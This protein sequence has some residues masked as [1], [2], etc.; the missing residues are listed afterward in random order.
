M[1]KKHIV[2]LG[3]GYAG[4]HAAKNL[5]KAFKK[6]QDKVEITLIDKNRHHILMTELHEVAGNRVGEES[7]KIS[8]DRIFSGKMVNVVQDT[9][10]DIDFKGQILKGERSSY[11]YDQLIIGTGAQTADFNIPGVK[12]HAFYLWSLDDA[13]RIRCH[14]E[15][16]V[17]DASREADQ[18]K[19]EQMLTFVI[20]GGGFTGVELVGEL[21][22][23]LPTLCKD[24]GIDF[25]KEVRLINCEALGNILNMLPEKPRAKAVKYMEKKGV[26]IM[27]NS[28]ITHVDAEGFTTRH[29]DVIKTKTLIWTCGV[30]GTE[31]CER[32]P[33]TDGKIGRKAVNEYMQSPDYQNV[34]L[35]G[36]GMWFLENDRA[37]PQIVEAAE[38][39]AKTAA[40]GVTY[41]IKSEMGIKAEH[42]K[43]FKS[44][45]HGFMVSIG[46]RYAVSHTAGM[47]LSGFFA[48]ALKHMVNMYYQAGVCGINGAWSYF[49]HE[50]LEIKQKRS[51]I[52]G[53]ASYKVPSYWTTFLR[54][55]LGVMW[56]IEGVGKI[57][58]GWLTDTTGSKVY[59][60]A[61]AAAEAGADA[62][63]SA[64][65]AVV[66]TVASASQAVAETGDATVEAVKQFAPPLLSQPLAIFTWIN[67]T[68]VAQA[69][70]LFQLM[71]VLAELGIGLALFAGLFTFPAAIVSLGLSVMFLIGALAGKEILWY[72]AVSIVMLGGAGKAFGLDYWVMPYLKKLWNKTPLA[73]KTYF[74]LG[75]PEFT[76]RQM[77][78]KLGKK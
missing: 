23:W 38:Q 53:L 42:P 50:I 49:K 55:Y 48:Q 39:T 10:G 5:H 20:A 29:G 1:D 78:K 6:Y 70:Y 30:R 25:K 45:F 61:P 60:G 35:V 9:I 13:L 58:E 64:S 77:E 57:K 44:N 17:K 31:F 12:E 15:Q 65:Q 68:F 22:E 11:H 14:I 33:L 3:G 27:L 40:D 4:V 72:M 66:E 43:P 19:R 52:G 16:M 18:E 51:L 41:T 47:S 71:I 69:P 67:D 74:Y 2:V 34:Y 59:W 75:E 73:K 28:L 24:N 63:A 26:E 7:V 62:W 76:R 56:F 32:L 37:V 36:D 54:M 46:G 21:T 8:F